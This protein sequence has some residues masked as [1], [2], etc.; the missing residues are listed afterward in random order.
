MIM[1][2]SF[3]LDGKTDTKTD[4]LNFAIHRYPKSKINQATVG[5]D[6]RFH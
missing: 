5:V 4:T 6:T 2:F 1:L 3:T